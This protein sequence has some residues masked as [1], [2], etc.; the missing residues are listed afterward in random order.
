MLICGEGRYKVTLET[1]MLGSDHLFLLYGGE[2]P[3]IGGVVICEPEKNPQV[4]SLGTHYDHLVLTPLA[5]KGCET[6]QTTVVAIGGI[7][8]DDASKEEIEQ[9]KQNCQI[10]ID[11][12]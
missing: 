4:I 11:Q 9:I 6:Y 3:H 1:K 5:K 7:H 2:K 10:L 12:L 8:I